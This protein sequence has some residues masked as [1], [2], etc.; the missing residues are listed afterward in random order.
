MAEE[1]QIPI[2]TSVRTEGNSIFIKSEYF[3][4]ILPN[5]I[6]ALIGEDSNNIDSISYIEGELVIRMKNYP[7]NIDYYINQN[8]ELIVLS[9]TGDSDNYFINVDGELM[10]EG[11]DGQ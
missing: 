10:W 11:D 9:N 5:T 3:N 4:N 6:L 1:R 8:G 7:E 2:I